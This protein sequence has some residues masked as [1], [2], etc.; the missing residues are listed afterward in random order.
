MRK[1]VEPKVNVKRVFLNQFKL[2]DYLEQQL[3]VLLNKR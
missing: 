2:E 1:R 3:L